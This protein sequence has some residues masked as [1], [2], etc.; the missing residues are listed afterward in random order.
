M[1]RVSSGVR[2]V[3][4][5]AAIGCGARHGPLPDFSSEK[6]GRSNDA[7]SVEDEVARAAVLSRVRALALQDMQAKVDAREECPAGQVHVRELGDDGTS[8]QYNAEAC[9]WYQRYRVATPAAAVEVAGVDVFVASE[10][11]SG[12]RRITEFPCGSGRHLVGGE[13]L[14]LIDRSGVLCHATLVGAGGSAGHGWSLNGC[15]ELVRLPK[16]VFAMRRSDAGD[17]AV[18]RRT[19]EEARPEGSGE[20]MWTARVVVDLVGNNSSR[21]EIHE[22]RPGT[23]EYECER[24]MVRE[25]GEYKKQESVPVTRVR[26]WPGDGCKSYSGSQEKICQ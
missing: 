26:W 17:G 24:L 25:D 2:F 13:Q 7:G 4:L 14:V 23:W 21:V 8:K 12:E 18:V 16:R 10:S 1:R 6:T 20:S 19:G 11:E 3:V 9:G 15:G 22:R 5:I